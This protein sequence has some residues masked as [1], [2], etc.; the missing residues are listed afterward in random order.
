MPINNI[1]GPMQSKTSQCEQIEIPAEN[2]VKV[3]RLLGERFSQLQNIFNATHVE[4]GKN[5]ASGRKVPFDVQ[6]VHKGETQ[7]EGLREYLSEE[8]G[9]GFWDLMKVRKGLFLSI[10]DAKYK[11]PVRFSLAAE[12]LFKIRI[13]ISGTL[14]S[15]DGNV[16]AQGGESVLHTINPKTGLD[17]IVKPDNQR[18]RMIVLHGQADALKPLSLT[19]E[20]L[21]EPFQQIIQ[22]GQFPDMEIPL[23]GPLGLN[24][25]AMD[26]LHS[27]DRFM[28]E[29][30]THY[31]KA[32]GEELLSIVLGKTGTQ[33]HFMVG[34]NKLRSADITRIHEARGILANNI[35][36][37]PSN[38]E[39][40]NL[41]GMNQTK[42]KLGFREIFDETIQDFV[43]R[44]RLE[45]AL[46]MVENTDLTLAEIGYKVGYGYPTNF[47]QAF[48]RRF[49]K[50]PREAR[51]G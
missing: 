2:K 25:L 17:Y 44:R 31:L 11:I 7:D 4:R 18:L 21:G 42:L 41:I 45:W 37:P 20:T 10:T 5:P 29:I 26:I 28:P 51:M 43:T 22:T 27:R 30:R 1:F 3:G 9:E 16:L 14:L 13:M 6:D 36:S 47:T 23:S 24:H 12:K 19:P 32:K 15:S 33:T 40:S 34:R 50:T 48:K 8:E 39:L 49:G 35:A 38:S 46:S